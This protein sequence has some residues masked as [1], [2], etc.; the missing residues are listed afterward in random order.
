[1][2]G[3]ILPP[4]NIGGSVLAPGLPLASSPYSGLYQLSDG[5]G[6][7]I[8]Q[9]N[10]FSLYSALWSLGYKPPQAFAPTAVAGSPFATGVNPQ[11]VVVSSDGL[12]VYV[13]NLTA[14]T[15][16]GYSRNASTG[17]LTAL[18]GSPY[19]IGAGNPFD[20]AITPNGAFVLV[21][22]SPANTIAVF[23]RNGISGALT[24]V[25]GSPFATGI[26]GGTPY[27]ITVSP[28]GLFALMSGTG[29]VGSYSINQTTGALTAVAGSPYAAG[30]FS[31]FV[32][33]SP[34][35][36]FAYVSNATASTISAYKRNLTTG[37]LTAVA[38]SPFATN[39]I[40]GLQSLTVTPDGTQLLVLHNVSSLVYVFNIDQST[41][42]LT[43][44][45]GSP[46]ATG[47]QPYQLAVSPAGDYVFISD[48]NGGFMTHTRNTST[49]ALAVVAGSPF[50]AG[51]ATYGITITPD[52]VHI[53]AVDYVGSNAYVYRL[54]ATAT[55]NLLN[56]T[57]DGTG[58]L[59]GGLT[60]NGSLQ[61]NGAFLLNG[62]VPAT[63]PAFAGNG[64]KFLRLDTA[65]AAT[66]WDN[67]TTYTP[68]AMVANAGAF[69]VTDA[70]P[71]LIEVSGVLTA[72]G[73]LTATFLIPADPT[74]VV[75]D[76]VTTGNFALVLNGTY[77]IPNGRSFWYWNGVTLELVGSPRRTWR[78]LGGTRILGTTYTNNTADDMEVSVTGSW[79]SSAR[80]NITVDGAIRADIE[81]R[82]ATAGTLFLVATVPS[83]ST[84]S[85]NQTTSV[86]TL[87][88]WNELSL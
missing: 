76:N 16:S 69:T 83:G 25:A 41:G 66:Q 3:F 32:A 13:V 71:Y 84:Y 1:M 54:A 29:G 33:V 19:A 9:K 27:G 12:T 67:I 49:G 30:A 8:D 81:N 55:Y 51:A 4:T 2:G 35:G 80:A 77:T 88:T 10:Y 22:N 59:G 26:P 46:Y 43:N 15:I 57:F 14:S 65:G 5:V 61:V 70:A 68:V 79:A 45:A 20:I 53:I 78:V 6:M 17:V 73:A 28:D 7:A 40:N 60:I 11:S 87:A 72:N 86:V 50:A 42:V 74:T 31:R 64:G 62:G 24:A 36:D 75:F 37:V 47:A 34:N 18:T 44:S 52:G 58:G 85:V 23:A 63:F 38:G 82:A 39:G 21:T 56:A 48:G